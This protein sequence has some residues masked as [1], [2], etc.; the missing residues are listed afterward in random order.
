MRVARGE[1]IDD[2]LQYSVRFGQCFSIAEPQNGESP[3][4]QSMGSQ[5][6]G[7]SSVG[8]EVLAPIE[9][10]DEPGFEAGKVS[11]VT[12][13]WMLS[14]ELPSSNLAIAQAPPDRTL[15]IG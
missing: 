7:K 14:A 9:L 4:L 13:A 15:R 1:P 3:L 12:P 2:G 10:N 6:V 11:E 8:L 5:V